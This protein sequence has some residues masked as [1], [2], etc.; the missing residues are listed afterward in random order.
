MHPVPLRRYCNKYNIVAGCGK[1]SS[2]VQVEGKRMRSRQVS[3]YLFG[4]SALLM[5]TLL[6]T[7]LHEGTAWAETFTVTNTS[8]T[9][10]GSLREAIE[11]ANTT[12]GADEVVFAE[13][14]G[15]TITLGSQ[16][17]TVTDEA[18][19]VID[20]GGDV[21]VSG[22]NQVR[23]FEV[24]GKLAL[25]NLTITEGHNAVY[26]GGILNL[27][28]LTVANSTISG[29]S[30][31]L[32]GGGGIF[33]G[34]YFFGDEI[35]TLA[36]TDSTFSD[37]NA[38]N[39]GG[40]FNTR[41]GL[42]TVTNS[43]FSDNNADD[44]AGGSGGGIQVSGGSTLTVT[45]S[46]FSNNHASYSGGGISSGGETQLTAANST[47]S[48]NSATFHG[49]GISNSGDT[50]VTNS[51]FFANS[52]I[53]STGYGGGI[54]NTMMLA[55][56]NS[57]FSDNNA[58]YGGG[59]ANIARDSNPNEPFGVA[60]TLSNTIIMADNAQ[61]G[62]CFEGTY[63]LPNPAP[64]PFE[65]FTDGGYNTDSGTSCGFSEDTGSISNTDP[66][67]DP[68]GL[69]DNGGP[70]ETIALLPDSPA[71]DLGGQEVCPPPQ[72]DQRGVERPQGEACDSGAFELEQRPPQ[73]KSKAECKKGGWEE[74]GFNNQGRCIAFVNRA[75]N[76]R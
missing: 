7:V 34:Q 16:L 45:D 9:G 43:T 50:R 5:M 25:R 8:D 28:H 52:A 41:N 13:G 21:T 60:A 3:R 27:G 76:T 72:T 31:R 20:G 22:N 1:C 15:G 48:N 66:L 14:V 6:L 18:G 4:T 56:K 12:A 69:Q 17:P 65:S 24:V 64:L 75:T 36:I 70:T 49:G 11:E 74:F 53:S 30:A 57:T 44:E 62:N 37:N 55:V 33:N 26:G 38:A 19:L 59:V 40:I 58:A 51:T 67:L 32:L 47:F 39:G 71:V 68:A 61:S 46:T 10:A 35:G 63:P 73:P 2:L 42:L 54:A 23:V 29:N